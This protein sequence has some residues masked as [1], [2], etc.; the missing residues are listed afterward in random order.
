MAKVQIEQDWDAIKADPVEFAENL[1]LG[2]D[3]NPFEVFQSQAKILRGIKRRI[4]LNTGRQFSKSTTCGIL[5]SHEAITHANWH[6]C[7]IQP[8]LEQ[9]RILCDLVQ[10]IST[11]Q[12]KWR[13]PRPL[14]W[15]RR[16]SVVFSGSFGSASG[17]GGG[18]VWCL[19]VQC[20]C[21][22]MSPRCVHGEH[23]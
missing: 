1:L 6:I 14:W 2:P 17:G 12:W 16:V 4:V 13:L 5:T 3:G 11:I 18:S 10:R 7:V 19:Q 15:F 9:S 21:G 8:S 23:K 20:W 22:V